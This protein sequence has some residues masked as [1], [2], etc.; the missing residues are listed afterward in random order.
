MPF[1][2]TPIKVENLV[3]TTTYCQ[4]DEYG[5]GVY[6]SNGDHTVMNAQ[7]TVITNIAGDTNTQTATSMN[8]TDMDSSGNSS[9]SYNGISINGNAGTMSASPTTLSVQN[10]V[11]TVSMTVDGTVQVQI[12]DAN[13]TTD[14]KSNTI[15]V[16][17]TNTNVW[18]YL[19]IYPLPS[20]DTTL[21]LSTLPFQ[22]QVFINVGNTP[23]TISA[24]TGYSIVY[25]RTINPVNIS[26]TLNTI[27][28]SITFVSVYP[29]PDQI[30]LI[31]SIVGTV[32]DASP[33]IVFTPVPP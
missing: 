10:G 31:Q 25:P 15:Q 5:V 14:I 23:I 16:F 20:E 4:A 8:L 2:N 3:D 28:Q 33:D 9:Y 21:L 11:N 7:S 29:N 1:N 6:L 17:D 32:G 22:Q 24:P 12:I 13:G 30:F 18:R 26:A 27:G 19:P